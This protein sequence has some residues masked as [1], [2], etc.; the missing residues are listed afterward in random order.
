MSVHSLP[1]VGKRGVSMKAPWLAEPLKEGVFGKNGQSAAVRFEGRPFIVFWNG[2]SWDCELVP[3]NDIPRF[4][5]LER[6]WWVGRTRRIARALSLKEE[7]LEG[8]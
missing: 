3:K 1:E 6:E 4:E 5:I 7:P 2:G 8:D